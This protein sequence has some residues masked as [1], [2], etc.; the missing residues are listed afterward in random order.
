MAVTIQ[1]L[2]HSVWNK[3]LCFIVTELDE[4]CDL[5]AAWHL[6]KCPEYTAY[7]LQ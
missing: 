1:A 3:E 6:A 5:S 7:T 2:C 4:P